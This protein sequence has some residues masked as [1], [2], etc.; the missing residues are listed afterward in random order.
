MID[1]QIAKVKELIARREEIDRQLSEF[2]SGASPVK[3]TVRCSS[4]GTFGHTVRTCPSTSLKKD[5][6]LLTAS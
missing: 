5:D 2:F 6:P 4:C 3:K 1:E